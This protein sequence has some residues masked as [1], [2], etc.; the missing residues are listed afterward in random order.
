MENLLNFRLGKFVKDSFHD[1]KDNA[2]Q[3][4]TASAPPMLLINHGLKP[5]SLSL[6]EKAVE[7][8]PRPNHN[9]VKAA[10]DN[11]TF[12]FFGRKKFLKDF[13]REELG[14][15]ISEEIA[16]NKYGFVKAFIDFG[17]KAEPTAENVALAYVKHGK[18]FADKLNELAPI[19]GRM[20]EEVSKAS[21]QIAMQEMAMFDSKLYA[22]EKPKESWLKSFDWGSALGGLGQIVSAVQPKTANPAT[23]A[24]TAAATKKDD[25]KGDDD[26]EDDKIL[27]V[28]KMMFFAGIVV[29]VLGVVLYF[30]SKNGGK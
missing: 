28:P 27:G 5:Q 9:A 13:S 21:Q 4:V 8:I 24:T 15:T 26:K 3:K 12:G 14:T 20:G 22:D 18:A 19:G 10:Q 23:A 30:A 6:A 17:I 25:K 1:I 29:V 16:H 2:V 11:I 7:V